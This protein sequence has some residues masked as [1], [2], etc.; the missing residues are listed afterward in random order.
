MAIPLPPLHIAIPIGLVV[1]ISIGILWALYH[2]NKKI[3]KKIIF[4]K[5]RFSRY[6]RGIENLKDVPGS[7]EKD[8]ERL[9]KY[10]RSFF[11]EYH[12][13][14]ENLTYLELAKDFEKKKKPK[15]VQLSKLMSAIKYRGEKDA[16][17]VNQ[18]INLFEKILN[19][20]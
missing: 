17:S 9:D 3:Y 6:K 20:Y 16:K 19:S 13:L 14:N 12:A 1:I 8:F 18:A 2:R 15:Y 7:P 4:E 10:L 11:K 5:T